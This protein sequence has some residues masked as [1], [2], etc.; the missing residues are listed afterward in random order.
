VRGVCAYEGAARKAVHMLKFRSGRYLA[1]VLGELMR[2]S[3]R[4][5]PM[6]ADLIVP[7][8]L[9]PRRLRERGY[10][11]ASLL[12]EQVAATVRAPVTDSLLTREDRPSQRTLNAAERRRNLEGAIGCTEPAAVDGRKVLL[13]DDVLTTGSTLNACAETLVHAGATRVTALV[14]ARAM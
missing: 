9:A 1:P 3:L 10:N 2:Y 13:V 8:P 14:F 6:R 5:H 7:V 11:Q 4:R 12:G